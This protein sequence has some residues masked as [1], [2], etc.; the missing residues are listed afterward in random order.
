MFELILEIFSCNQISEC[1]CFV[2]NE[3][4]NKFIRT[5]IDSNTGVGLGL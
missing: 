3:S 4:K 2:A 1:E 5:K